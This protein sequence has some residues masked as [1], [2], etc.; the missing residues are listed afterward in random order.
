MPNHFHFFVKQTIDDLKI[1]SF[2][3]DLQNSYTKFYNLKYK[4][5][6]VI[7]QGPAKTK[8]IDNETYFIW[9]IK[10]ILLN[11]LRANL[12]KSVTD[13]KF[14]SVKDYYQIRNGTLN[15]KV[16]ILARFKNIHDFTVFIEDKNKKIDYDFFTLF[17]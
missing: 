7:L 1:G 10:Y 3:S 12:V 5:S 14:S 11:P 15:D 8:L 16:E 13:W 6:G 4:H 9:L 17:D 2:I